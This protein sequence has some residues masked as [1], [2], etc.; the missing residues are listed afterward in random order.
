MNTKERMK[1]NSMVNRGEIQEIKLPF[2]YHQ[3]LFGW[4]IP[5]MQISFSCHFAFI[6]HILYLLLFHFRFTYS[7]DEY[8]FFV[9][10]H[11]EIDE[12]LKPFMAV[13]FEMKSKS[14]Y[15]DRTNP[16]RSMHAYIDKKNAESI[17]DWD[18]IIGWY[19]CSKQFIW[20][21][22]FVNNST[23]LVLR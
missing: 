20:Y 3:T 5:Y 6:W 23:K 9:T 16:C 15:S 11:V 22:K 2:I 13:K 18:S 7:E 4:E 8:A 12:F 17:H 21:R 14:S 10:F 1:I 19:S